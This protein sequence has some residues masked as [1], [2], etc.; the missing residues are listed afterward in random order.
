[1]TPNSPQK[2]PRPGTSPARERIKS[3]LQAYGAAACVGVLWTTLS[4]IILLPLPPGTQTEVD[5]EVAGEPRALQEIR[6]PATIEVHDLARNE[7]VLD[8]LN[9]NYKRVWAYEESALDRS[10]EKL[11]AAFDIVGSFAPKTGSDLR[12]VSQRLYEES[13]IGLSLEDLQYLYE[14][15]NLNRLLRDLSMV[16]TRTM[17]THFIVAGESTYMAQRNARLVEYANM[18]PELTGQGTAVPVLEYPASVRTHVTEAELRQFYPGMHERRLVEI[19]SKILMDVVEPNLE[20]SPEL[21]EHIRQEAFEALRMEPLKKV[22][23]EGDLIAGQFEA[24]DATQEEALSVLHD[25]RLQAYPYRIAAIFLLTFTCLGAVAIYVGRFRKEIRFNVSNVTMIC[26]PILLVLIIGRALDLL[27]HTENLGYTSVLF[28]SALVGMLSAIMVG[29]YVGFGM[30]VATTVLFG[31]ATGQSLDS[32]VFALFG[33]ITAVISLKTFR[34]RLDVLGAGSRVALVNI[35]TAFVLCIFRF[36]PEF[37]GML[38]LLAGINGMIY[39]AATLPIMLFFEKGFGVVTDMALL[40]L[41]APDNKLMRMMED[42]APGS[43]QHVLSVTKL[44]ESAAES[45]GANYLLV[46]AGA[47]FHDIGKTVK[48]KYFS[49][50]QVTLED[51]KVHSRISPYMSVLIIKNHVKE[52]IEI[53]RRAGLPQKVIDFIP[54]HHGTGLIRYFYNE[55]LHRYEDSE[56]MDP[57]REEDFRYPGP[58][59]QTIEAA[60]VLMADGVEAIV[61]SRFTSSQVNENELRRVVK[62]AIDERFQDG[63][64]DECDL[65]MRQLGQIRESFVK[66]L[67][68]RFHH[69]IAYPTLGARR[70]IQAVRDGRES[71][72]SASAAPAT[73]G[74]AG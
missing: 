73:A 37:D 54:Q 40:E 41:T 17:T 23:D 2:A 35:T 57:V 43:Y 47:Y 50:N 15:A 51:K 33:G 46:R 62:Q 52:G 72:E 56:S 58:K 44:A 27:S 28:P 74:A 69:R 42:T 64:F 55:A 3:F 66:T 10:L 4:A 48:P 36:P 14:E 53:A 39:A 71:R 67:K 61:T 31:V 20:F 11:N 63:Q 26:I 21:T 30:V 29:P 5:Y 13:E 68:A 1:M 25:L 6:A 60:I 9:R 65:T 49:E 38:L 7:R 70:E 8:E 32:T 24:L 16:L 19:G 34:K 18:P 12:D 45:I 59:P 22:Y